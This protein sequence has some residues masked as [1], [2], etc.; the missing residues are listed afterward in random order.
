[1]MFLIKEWIG[2]ERINAL[3]DY[4]DLGHDDLEFILSEAGKFCTNELLPLN[5][6][7][8]EH[9]ARFE[10][11]RVTTP[12]G[13]KQAY[14]QFIENG[15]TGIDAEPAHG[16]WSRASVRER[17]REISIN[18]LSFTSAVAEMATLPLP[19][20]LN[21]SSLVI[22]TDSSLGRSSSSTL[23]LGSP[24]FMDAEPG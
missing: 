14:R 21:M 16:G 18:A 9:G 12:P 20:E 11:G 1:M 3:P 13:F 2:M 4:E 10:D 24:S 23:L 8:D 17:L 7:G 5:R 22:T 6:E 19:L 15:W